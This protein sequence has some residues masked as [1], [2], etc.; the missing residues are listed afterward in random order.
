MKMQQKT[1]KKMPDPHIRTQALVCVNACVGAY[2][3]FEIGDEKKTVMINK[4]VEMMVK[5][6]VEP[7]ITGP[8]SLTLFSPIQRAIKTVI[9]IA[10]WVT[11]KVTQ[12]K[13]QLPVDTVDKPA[14]YPCFLLHLITSG[15]YLHILQ[16]LQIL[17]SA[18]YNKLI[19]SFSV[20]IKK[21][22]KYKLMPHI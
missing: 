11:T 4:I 18:I 22:H 9:P 13:I 5:M 7:P 16:R 2:I 21:R 8:I 19:F 17:L 14:V 10:S 1:I 3:S 12:F 15:T 6:S 20:V